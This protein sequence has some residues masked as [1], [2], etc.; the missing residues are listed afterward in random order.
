MSPSQVDARRRF[1][2]LSLAAAAASV[3]PGCVPIGSPQA[4]ELVWGR[5]GLSDGRFL[6]PRAISIDDSDDLYIVDTTGRI[7]VFDRDG[8]R[9]RGWKTPQ[10]EN[11]RPTG[12]A[13]LTSTKQS[14]LLVADTHYYRMLV[15]SLAGELMPEETI[16]GV[17]GIRPGEFAFVTDAVCDQ[18]GCYYVGEYGDSDRIQKFDPEGTFMTQWGGTGNTPGRFKRPQSLQVV[19]D[20]LWVVDACNHRIQRFDVTTSTPELIDIWGSQSDQPG[21]ETGQFYY[22]YDLAIAG[23]GSV[24]VCEYGNQRLQRFASDGSWIATWGGPGILPGQ[25]YQP[26]G[27]VI[28]SY[29]RVHILDSNNHR[30]QRIALPT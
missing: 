23:D 1:L 10:T 12:L 14:R 30:V 2:G 29:D 3:V 17:A 15:Y 13:C 6:K 4:P 11:G 20:V 26:W 28:D 24:V 22:P 27:V 19:D 9:K 25:L 21:R 16:G 5:R 18:Q 8:N 7:Q